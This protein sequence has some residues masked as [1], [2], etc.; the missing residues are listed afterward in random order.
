[1]FVVFGIFD[2]L[3]LTVL[4]IPVMSPTLGKQIHPELL[5][6]FRSRIYIV[7]DLGEEKEAYELSASLGWRG[8]VIKLP[9]TAKIKDPA[10]FLEM[11]Q[12][13]VLIRALA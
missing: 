13:N 3:A 11:A 9:Y 6:R 2:A 8:S 1:M 10:G 12:E 7:P 4:R 5:N